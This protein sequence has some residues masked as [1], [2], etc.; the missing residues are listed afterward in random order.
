M[1]HMRVGV[2]ASM[3]RTRKLKVGAFSKLASLPSLHRIS[4]GRMLTRK[5]C[6]RGSACASAM[7]VRSSNDGTCVHVSVFVLQLINW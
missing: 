1:L 7:Y 6:V 2:R 4:N 3:T 5:C